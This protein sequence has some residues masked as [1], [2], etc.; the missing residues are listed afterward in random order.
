MFLMSITAC[1]QTISSLQDT[2][3]QVG[4]PPRPAATMPANSMEAQTMPADRID[5]P[6][7]LDDELESI[8]AAVADFNSVVVRDPGVPADYPTLPVMTLKNVTLGQFLQFVRAAYPGVEI[9][10]IDGPAGALYSIRIRPDEE[11]MRR[12]SF[13]ADARADANRVRLYRLADV[14]SALSITD[15]LRFGPDG[16]DVNHDEIVK[17][18][19]NQVLSLLQAALDQTD[20]DGPVTL[21]IHEPTQTLMFKG[22]RAKQDVLE[23]ALSTLQPGGGRRGP[24]AGGFYSSPVFPPQN[25]AFG[26][27]DYQPSAQQFADQAAK[28]Q[29]EQQALEAQRAAMDAQMKALQKKADE[30]ARKTP[31]KD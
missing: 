28:M 18:A 16:K 14:V 22:S 20:Q 12:A 5:K 7:L 19:T 9:V 13:R 23:E 30:A 11:A 26:A 1:A 29:A 8:R 4:L 27:S 6:T 17:D 25:N 10:R 15:K 2:R 31:S 24:R 3:Q 21:K